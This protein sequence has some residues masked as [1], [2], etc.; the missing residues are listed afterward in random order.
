MIDVALDAERRE[1]LPPE[2]A[3]RKASLLRLRPILMTTM[4]AHARRAAHGP[5]QRAPASEL[6]RPLGIAIIGGLMVS[7]V[8]TLYT[9]PA[10]YLAID[11]LRLRVRGREDERD[12]NPPSPAPHPSSLHRC[13]APAPSVR[14]ISRRTWPCRP[15][16][17]SR[18]SP[19][20]ICFSPPS[21][22]D[23]VSRQGWWDLF[24]EAQL[25]ELEARLMRSNPT[26]GRSGG[27]CAPGASTRAAGPGGV[28]PSDHGYARRRPAPIPA[29]A[30]P[31]RVRRS[32]RHRLRCRRRRLLGSGFVGA[33][34]QTRSRPEPRRRRRLSVIWRAPA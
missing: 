4:A 19:M 32:A 17:R 12:E 11:R 13:W 16:T 7:Q 14:A 31:G 21:P 5:Q 8:L 27:A 28:L 6:R 3:I 24:G 1:G 2:A 34:P 33:H 9:T 18:R 26:S 30:S 29:R 10:L 25:N 22:R 23:H 20:P 15:R